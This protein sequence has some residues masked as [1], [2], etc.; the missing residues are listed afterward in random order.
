MHRP[1]LRIASLFVLLTAC[2]ADEVVEPGG[3]SSESG[4]TTESDDATTKPTTTKDP[5]TTEPTTADTS[6]STSA[7]TTIDTDTSTTTPVDTDTDTDTDTETTSEPVL[8]GNGVIDAEEACDGDD[9]AGKTCEG[10]GFDGGTLACDAD[11][12]KLDISGCTIASC[13]NG[14]VEGIE[15]CDGDDLAGQDCASQGFDSGTL[16][17]AP[18][19]G[20]FDTS[21]CIVCGN[22]KVDGADVCDGTDLAGADCMSQGFDDGTLACAADCSAYDVSAC[23]KCGDAIVSGPE[24]CDSAELDGQDCAMQGFDGGDLACAADCGGFVTDGCYKC[25]DGAVNGPEVCDGAELDGATCASQGFTTGTLSCQASCSAFNTSACTTCGNNAIEGAEVCDALQVG[26]NT[27]ASMGFEAGYVGC[28]NLCGAVNFA[29]CLDIV[30][31]SEPNDDAMVATSTLDFLAENAD[32]PFTTSTIVTGAITLGDDDFYAITNPTNAPVLVTAETYGAALGVCGGIDTVLDLRDGSGALILTDDEGGL[33]SCSRISNYSLAANTTVYLRVIDYGDNTA[34][35]K[36]HAVID[37]HGSVCGDGV[38]VAPE[39]CDDGNTA[40][41]DGCSATC[42]IQ[43]TAEIEPNNTNAQAD[44]TGLVVTSHNLYTG[45]ITP[46]GDLD[47]YRVDSVGPKVFHFE[48]FSK[49]NDCTG[50][51]LNM[52]L[53]NAA[54]VALPAV[55][56]LGMGIGDCAALTYTLPDGASYVQVEEQGNNATV[57]SYLFDAAVL[58]D[59]GAESE[60]N[61]TIAT[62]DFNLLSGT[63][64]VVSGDHTVETDVDYYAIQIPHR[65]SLRVELIEGDTAA[66]TCESNKID[67][68]ITLYNSAGTV[69]VEDDDDTRGFCSMIDGTGALPLDEGARN[70]AAGTYYIAV[71]NSNLASTADARQ[72][73]YKLAVQVRKP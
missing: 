2:P 9:L 28:E 7:P 53:F 71:R 1:D 35:A 32:G 58:A 61:D 4:G 6:T 21:G 37:I 16:V 33:G 50:M 12:T 17:C 63:N 48:T 10:E 73:I 20:E 57:A 5:D 23:F 18:N 62:A 19:C 45:A 42:T 44:A 70:L 40:A 41:G 34:I 59:R 8:C 54:G 56:T 38:V 31:E 47:R 60:P 3:S 46:V 24:V 67:S 52:R 65:S 15:A 29:N 26:N 36:Y 55:D 27:C 49:W 25:G 72:F 30:D 68:L 51:T 69:L 14:S 22:D 43:G 13:G 64:I 39:T 11:C 66:E